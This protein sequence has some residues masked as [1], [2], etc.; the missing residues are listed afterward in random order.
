MTTV[1]QKQTMQKYVDSVNQG[2]LSIINELC[3]K[4][5]VYHGIG[6]ESRLSKDAYL[7]FLNEVRQAFPDFNVCVD[8]LIAEDERVAYR[9]TISGTHKGEFKGLAP[10]GKKFTTSTIGVVLFKNGKIAEEW[11]IY[12]AIGMMAQLGALTT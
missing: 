10:T 9:M 2:K 12:D 1:E 7:K 11:E 5:Y 4:N 6:E 8:E 3:D